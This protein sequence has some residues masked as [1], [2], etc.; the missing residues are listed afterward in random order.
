MSTCFALL[1]G[2]NVGGRN[3]IPMKRLRE[4]CAQLGWQ[5]VQTYIQSGNLVYDAAGTPRDHEAALE[6][7]VLDVL[8]L[9]VPVIARSASQLQQLINANPFADIADAQPSRVMLVLSKAT[10]HAGAVQKLQQHS[11]QGE[12]VKA[13]GDA[14]WIYFPQGQGKSK[15]TMPLLDRL[16][17]STVTTRNWRTMLKLNDMATG[18]TGV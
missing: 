7:A 11:T 14:L 16:V 10:A 5:N 18:Q 12:Q 9:S 13:A 17:G 1:R 6:T 3:A 2:I 4:L 8:G 15:L